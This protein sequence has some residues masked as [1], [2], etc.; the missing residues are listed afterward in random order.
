[1][2]RL[3]TKECGANTIVLCDSSPGIWDICKG[4]NNVHKIHGFAVEYLNCCRTPQLLH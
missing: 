3:T 2:D 1:M 4:E